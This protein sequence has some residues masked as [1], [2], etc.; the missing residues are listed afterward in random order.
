M[1]RFRFT[2]YGWRTEMTLY[3]A[4]GQPAYCG[5]C[6]WG[7]L[8]SPLRQELT[9]YGNTITTGGHVYCQL[10]PKRGDWGF[11]VMEHMDHCSHHPALADKPAGG[12]ARLQL[13]VPT[14]FS[15]RSDP[16]QADCPECGAKFGEDCQSLSS[17]R[18][19]RSVHDKRQERARENAW[20]ASLP[21]CPYCGV[22]SGRQCVEQGGVELRVIHYAREKAALHKPM[23]LSHIR[24]QSVAQ[25]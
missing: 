18:S 15:A 11:P 16:L 19:R 8:R 17:G 9:P 13:L 4:D 20:V 24:N 23:K 22:A 14:N 25:S 10:N 6:I 2:S 7:Q 3:D 21:E 5:N 12:L 1:P